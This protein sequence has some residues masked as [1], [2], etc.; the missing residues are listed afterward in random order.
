MQLHES[1]PSASVFAALGDPTRLM[2]LN[3]LGPGE[4]SLSALAAGAGMSR[5]AISKHLD[6]LARAGL[7]HGQ[8]RGREHRYTATP[9]P[10]REAT[11]WLEAYRSQWSEA[12]DRLDTYLQSIQED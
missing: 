2:L 6:V 9:G 4:R 12:F 5:Q 8:R 11:E 3:R 1:P 7:V 10:L